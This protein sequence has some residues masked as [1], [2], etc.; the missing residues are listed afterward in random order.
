MSATGEFVASNSTTSSFSRVVTCP[1][2]KR[3]VGVFTSSDL[4]PADLG[5]T[6]PGDASSS[7]F[8][9]PQDSGTTV[10]FSKNNGTAFTV[11][12][13]MGWTMQATCLTAP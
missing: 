13:K 1:T 11:N 2:G 7:V 3:V 12:D 5:P 9:G 6:V 10:I 8:N 4:Q